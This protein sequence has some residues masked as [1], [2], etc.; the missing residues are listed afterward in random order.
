MYYKKSVN[1]IYEELSSSIDGLSQE[2]ATE[3][4]NVY[5]LNKIDDGKRVSKLSI[6]LKQ[7]Q[8]SM[9]IML[10]IVSVISFFILILCMILIL[11]V[12]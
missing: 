7:F 3:R 6:F 2:E 8:D 11:I 10:L 5:G 1:E 9:I 12:Y 4:L